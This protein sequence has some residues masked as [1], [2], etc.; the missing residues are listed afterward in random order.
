MTLY[1]LSP[2]HSANR[3]FSYSLWDD[4]TLKMGIMG[5]INGI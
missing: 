3:E 2:N 5:D 1:E 4:D